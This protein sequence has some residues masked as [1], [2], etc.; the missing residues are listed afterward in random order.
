MCGL[1][2]VHS[3]YLFSCQWQF[4]ARAV[5]LAGGPP[6]CLN[7]GCT[8]S[9]ISSGVKFGMKLQAFSSQ[10]RGQKN[11]NYCHGLVIG[12]CVTLI[13]RFFQSLA[14]RL[15]GRGL[16]GELLLGMSSEMFYSRLACGASCDCA[17]AQRQDARQCAMYFRTK[18]VAFAGA[19]QG[20]RRQQTASLT[21]AH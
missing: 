3:D 17:L 5:C 9:C 7:P 1:R 4:L 6:C 8:L 11:G 14:Y 20:G 2:S 19:L 16:Y 13:F 21:I 10:G 12:Q 18:T 15:R